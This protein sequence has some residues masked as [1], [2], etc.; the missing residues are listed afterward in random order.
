L[1]KKRH[2]GTKFASTDAQHGS[3]SAADSE[4]LSSRVNFEPNV[5]ATDSA[6]SATT[7]GLSFVVPDVQPHIEFKKIRHVGQQSPKAQRPQD[8]IVVLRLRGWQ[9]VVPV[10]LV[11][12]LVIGLGWIGLQG[13]QTESHLTE[14]QQLFTRLQQQVEAGDSDGAKSTLGS[15]Q[16]VLR[17]TRVEMAGPAWWLGTQ[18]PLA[19]DDLAAARAITVALDDFA[20]R[21][22]PPLIDVA[23][24]LETAALKPSSG[25]IDLLALRAAAP[26][27]SS[28]RAAVEEARQRVAAIRTDGLA[29]KI[30]S[31]MSAILAKLDRARRIVV[32]AELSAR[33]LPP[34]FGADGSRTYL[35]MFQNLAEVRATGGIA[36]AYL[37]V[38]ANLGGVRIID[39]GSSAANLQVF[40]KSVLPLDP[41]MVDLHT[42]RLG[43]YPADVNLTPDFPTAATLIREMYRL[44]SGRTVD[45]VMATDPVALSYILK[46]TGPAPLTAGAPLAAETVVHRLLSE[47]YSIP[48][49]A[50]QDAFF[51]GAA[52]SVFDVLVAKKAD[53]KALLKAL[54]LAAGERRILAWS[55]H[56]EE[57]AQLTDTVLGGSL[58]TDDGDKPTVGVF[59]NDG[60]GAKL[61]YYLTHSATLSVGDCV[62]ADTAE[63]KLHLEI[64]STAPKSG[65]PPSVLGLGLS[66][67]LYTVRT[68][69]MVYSPTGGAIADAKLDRVETDM[70]TGTERERAV[71]V[72]T[73]DLPPGISKTLDVTVMTGKL[74]HT[75]GQL[76]PR[77]STTPGVAPWP[78]TVTPGGGCRR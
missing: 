69:V 65:L 41:A 11:V 20:S 1:R 3:L 24:S 52:K 37:V 62:N 57:Q 48:V 27:L 5:V 59:L 44:R 21:G 29:G 35:L 25:L 14:A 78:T 55:A 8:R 43:V 50:Q 31:A 18:L 51:A 54:I 67:D 10:G 4:S 68:N 75:K 74:P 60:S 46:A 47:V 56:P 16:R 70:G 36:G 76:R 30:L 19:G 23:N 22:L 7:S 64:G 17:A 72:F 9:V 39:Q 71:G 40:R 26:K 53:P 34:M 49:P 12:A 45:G 15:L 61:G 42:D 33:L 66:G 13:L 32:T 63:L 77:L 73:I 6:S 2:P 58:S 38:E 28:S